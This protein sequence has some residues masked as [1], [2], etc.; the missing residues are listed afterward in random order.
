M[1]ANGAVEM[2]HVPTKDH[3]NDCAVVHFHFIY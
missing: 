2:G 3:T 1:Y